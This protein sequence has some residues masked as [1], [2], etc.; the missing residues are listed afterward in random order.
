[1]TSMPNTMIPCPMC[2]RSNDL[3]TKTCSTCGYSFVNERDTEE[4]G[5]FQRLF[6]RFGGGD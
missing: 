1:M 2:G 6:G 5:F 4:P 3:K